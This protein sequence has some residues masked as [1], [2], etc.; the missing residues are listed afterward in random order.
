MIVCKQC[1]FNSENNPFIQ[2]NEEGLCDVCEVNMFQINSFKKI[3]TPEYLESMVQQIK[4]SKKGKYDCLIGISGGTDSSFLVYLAKKWGL[5][6]LLLHVDSGWNSEVSV[7]NI[8][9]IIEKSGY[10]FI[11]KVLPWGE[12]RDVQRSFILANV[13]DI[14]CPF[15]NLL[16]SYNYM[17]AQEYNI[18]YVLNGACIATEGIMPS[19]FA[20]YK[21]DKRNI[22][23][24]HNKWGVIKIKELKFIGIFEYLWFDKIKKIKFLSPLDWIEYNKAEAKKII[25]S[26]FNWK[27]YGWKHCEN[28]FTRF[29]QG[30][31]L[32]KKFKI[33]KRISHLSML[34]CSNQLSKDQ[35]KE[36]LENFPIYLNPLLERDDR[37]FFLKKLQLSEQAF[38]NYINIYPVSHRSYKSNL[39]F[40]DFFK[41]LYQ[42]LK[43]IFKFKIYNK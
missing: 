26:E 28:I 13:V 38:E 34:I 12:V 16:M 3:K 42:I 18:K 33:D 8:K 25:Q 27:D 5:N 35:A 4:D 6:P 2:L 1:L 32:P 22:M 39:D 30:Y 10:D 20:H 41:P 31:I 7:F 37:I 19:H 29:Y 36:I 9:Q 17:A 24:I 15:D 43:R 11:T 23:S 40:Y 14:D 21:L